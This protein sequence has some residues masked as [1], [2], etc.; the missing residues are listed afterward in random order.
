MSEHSS[1]LLPCL[2]VTPRVLHAGG[3]GKSIL[4][5]HLSGHKASPSSFPDGARHVGDFPGSVACTDLEWD[6][7]CE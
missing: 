4:G 6:L 5:G 3:L 7:S 1:E 2:G